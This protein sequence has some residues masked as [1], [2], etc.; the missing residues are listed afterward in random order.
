MVLILLLLLLLLLIILLLLLLLFLLLYFVLSVCVGSFYNKRE[1]DL[2]SW[3]WRQSD[4]F[5]TMATNHAR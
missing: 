1:T 4:E 3:D 2:F 5:S